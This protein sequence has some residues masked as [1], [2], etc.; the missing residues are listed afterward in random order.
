MTTAN[1]LTVLRLILVPFFFIWYFVGYGLNGV[2]YAVILV[3]LYGVAELTDL[4]DGKIARK[5][6]QVTDLGKVMD[7]FADV[8]SHLTYFTCFLMSGFMPVLAFAIIMWR[9]FS[10]SFLRMLLMGK[11]KPMAANIFGKAKTCMYAAVSIC[12]IAARVATS[13]GAYQDWMTTVMTVLGYVAA[14][15]SAISFIIYIDNVKKAGT[16]KDMTR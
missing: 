14:A 6:G 9:E 3:L 5:S 1:K 7:P 11:G 16:L 8:M 13:L 2:L 12:G 10:Q 15:A 4:L